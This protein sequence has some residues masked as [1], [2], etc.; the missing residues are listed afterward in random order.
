M[1]KSLKVFAP[2]QY[3]QKKELKLAKRGGGT[4]DDV[5]FVPD[6][7]GISHIPMGMGRQKRRVASGNSSTGTYLILALLG[8]AGVFF[9]LKTRKKK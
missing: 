1:I 2:D 6:D 9:I 3:S 7:Q 5:T 4:D 8:A